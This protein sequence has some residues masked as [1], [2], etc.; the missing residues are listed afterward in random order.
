M[1]PPKRRKDVLQ[2]SN[3]SRLRLVKDQVINLVIPMHQRC[4]ISRLPL[5]V[6]KEPNRFLEPRQPADL[7]ARFHILNRLLR[8]ANRAPRLNLAV[9][10]AAR[11]PVL[12]QPN[13]F[14]VDGVE[15]RQRLNRGLPHGGPLLRAHVGQ[16]KILDDAA[17]QKLHNVER[18]A[19]DGVVLAEA[20]GLRDGDVG[21]FEGMHDAVLALDFVRRL[22]DKF[23]GGLFAHDKLARVG[24]RDLVRRVGLTKAKLFVFVLAGDGEEEEG[25]SECRRYLLQVNRQLNLGHIFAQEL[26]EGN[27]VDGLTNS[28][29]HCK[30]SRPAACVIQAR[31][32]IQS[33]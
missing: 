31:M 30:S 15:A 1:P 16:R 6:H 18:R 22:G 2:D 10:K 19:D 4:P 26:A 11:L 17:V 14:V 3:D 27:L 7:L 5:L 25:A 12:P 21:V 20:V 13:L 23:A 32:N 9:V 8:H 29:S 33:F 24:G 28:A